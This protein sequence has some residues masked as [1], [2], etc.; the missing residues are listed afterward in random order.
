MCL[1]YNRPNS[2]CLASLKDSDLHLVQIARRRFTP[3]NKFLDTARTKNNWHP[4][5]RQQQQG[6]DCPLQIKVSRT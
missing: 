2:A 3:T 1:N 6:T 4:M 5:K